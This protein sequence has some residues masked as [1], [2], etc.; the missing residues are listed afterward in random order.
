MSMLNNLFKKKDSNPEQAGTTPE[1]PKVKRG[2]LTKE[3]KLT[4]EELKA[5]PISEITR[6]EIIDLGLRENTKADIFCYILMGLV[7]LMIFVPPVFRKVFY[8]PDLAISEV[9]TVYLTLDCRNTTVKEG[10]FLAE[11]MTMYYRDSEI[12]NVTVDFEY[13]NKKVSVIEN[14]P[15]EVIKYLEISDIEKK[16]KTDGH[17][18]IMDFEKNPELLKKQ[19]LSQFT[20]SAPAQ[21]T[22]MKSTEYICNTEYKT[23][24][25]VFKGDKVIKEYPAE[26]ETME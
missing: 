7:F 17:T 10:Y 2:Q 20:L 8:D 25:R 23:M 5:K 9:E 11:V 14:N 26:E 1:A 16:Q 24:I 15:K 18:F 3:K 13:T 22:N 21:I 4:V 6:E 19:E 12:L